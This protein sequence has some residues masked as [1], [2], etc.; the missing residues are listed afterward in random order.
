[1][2]SV[3]TTWLATDA[4]RARTLS[5]A[6]LQLHYAAQFG[7]ALGISYLEHQADDRHTN[8][9]WD[10]AL[11]ALMSHPAPGP[12]GA[13]S[14]G[15]RVRDLSIIVARDGVGVASTS[16][17]GITIA[18]AADVIRLALHR[19]GLDPRR[20]TLAR[21]YELPSHAV[22]A[23]AAFN[24]GDRAAFEQLSRWFGNAAIALERVA[25]EVK[26]AS[27]V[28]VW[29]HHFD[30][31]TLVQYPGGASTGAGLEPGD[32]YYDEPYFYVNAHPAPASPPPA[33]DL[34]GGGTWHT[35]EWIG[36]VLPGSRVTGD[37]AAQ[38]DQV[39][40][41][42]DSALAACRALVGA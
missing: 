12:R 41:Y 39:R 11:G 20:Y 27:D 14:V 28:R 24:A 22:G 9:G 30:I 5:D 31:A 40:R 42:L 3:N 37:A 33:A 26:G 2:S 15:V 8:L 29:P 7:T 4:A 23:G 19:Q 35:R 36:A 6:R 32:G 17:H 25:R 34:D 1:M 18:S 21:H 38:E 16:L 13:V 10:S